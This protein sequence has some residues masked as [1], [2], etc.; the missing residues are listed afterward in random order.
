MNFAADVRSIEQLREL[1]AFVC[2]FRTEAQDA[3]ASVDLIIR[4]ASDYLNDQLTFWRAAVRRCEDEVFQA[5]QELKQRQYVGFDGRVPDTTVQ[6]KNLQRA[7]ERLR[8]AEEKV[9]TVRRW[10]TRLPKQVAEVYDG[11]ARQLAATLEAE[12]PRALALLE[13]R[14]QSL[15]AYAALSAPVMPKEPTEPTTATTN[16][17][18]PAEPKR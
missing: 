10:M 4:R 7:K 12:L 17:S 3:L 1:H 14:I 5:N 13:R 11:P 18:S 9:A 15:E 2:R 16:Q 8:Y 6:E